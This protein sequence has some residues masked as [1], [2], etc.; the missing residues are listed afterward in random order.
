[1]HG[2]VEG[3]RDTEGLAAGNGDVHTALHGLVVRYAGLYGCARKRDQVRDLPAVKRQFQDAFILH[4]LAHRRASCFNRDDVGLDFDLFGN[5]PDFEHRVDHGI[6]VHLQ[7]DSGLHECAE[8]R[9][10]G[11]D[12]IR[13]YRHVRQDVS[14]RFIRDRAAADAGIGLRCRHFHTG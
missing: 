14:S 13:T 6:G 4:D 10:C 5:L 3:V 1:M 8:T 9:Q 12:A 2:A 11:F 7:D